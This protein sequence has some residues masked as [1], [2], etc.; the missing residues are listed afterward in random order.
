MM[1]PNF[2][3]SEND[4]CL[5][6]F[7]PLREADELEI[8]AQVL[9]RGAAGNVRVSFYFDDELLED[10]RLAVGEHAYGFANVFLPLDGKRGSHCVSV[11]LGAENGKAENGC[12]TVPI[13]IKG[14]S[15][16]VLDGGFV[17]LGPPNDR[18]PCDTFREALKSF[19]D[20]DWRRYVREMKKIG[21]NCVIIYDSQQY[22]R[23]ESKELRAHYP[24]R[25][26]P[27]SDICADDPIF[28]ILDEAEHTGQ[29]VFLGLGNPFG[30]LGAA[31]EM[32]ELYERYGRFRSFYGWY[33][34]TE[35][36]MDVREKKTFQNW[37]RYGALTEC[38]RKITPVKPILISP[39]AMPCG[40]FLRY[41]KKTDF[42]DVIMPQ[43]WVGQCAFHLRDSKRMH[44]KLK[45]ACRRAHKHL[46][47]NCESF[48][49]TDTPDGQWKNW[50][51]T[52]RNFSWDAPRLL[53][54][55]F[56]GGGMVGKR[57][58]DRQLAA[59]RP[60]VEKIMTFALT[61]FFCTT[62]FTPPCGGAAAVR[63]YE[64]YVEYRATLERDGKNGVE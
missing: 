31:E 45:T 61:G 13:E 48:N 62:G 28:A 47:A 29:K 56:R 41:L 4:V 36:R 59:A 22:L 1:E 16:P 2:F 37:E 53:V 60:Y 3:I 17:L 58:F 23:L 7:S 55:R 44:R 34:A 27:K 46:W 35:M 12:V 9:N 10:K 33:F 64:D 6:P 14:R 38:A 15:L 63:Q 57:G 5:L 32:A 18:K 39:M 8:R 24:S 50:G 19:T 25:L 54:P 21:M 11:R 30:Y 20:E 43:D 51:C 42:F 49:F 40:K 52:F 26:L